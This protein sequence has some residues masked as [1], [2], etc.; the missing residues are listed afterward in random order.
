MPV[1]LFPDLSVL[2]TICICYDED[3]TSLFFYTSF[4]HV[5]NI[6]LSFVFMLLF[7]LYV[8][9]LKAKKFIMITSTCRAFFEMVEMV[10]CVL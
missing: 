2:D 9:H 3:M 8:V 10:F 7:Y 1:I 6:I 4:C 5:S